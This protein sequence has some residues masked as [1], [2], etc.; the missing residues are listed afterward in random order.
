M[1]NTTNIDLLSAITKQ[2]NSLEDSFYNGIPS[3]FSQNAHLMH[4]SYMMNVV[5]SNIIYIIKNSIENSIEN[6]IQNS[7]ENSIQNVDAKRISYLE[8]ININY[9]QLEALSKKDNL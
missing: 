6:S 3:E 7:I 9:S 1:A 2:L 5:H 8:T 4:F